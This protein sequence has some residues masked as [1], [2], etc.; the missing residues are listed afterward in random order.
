MTDNDFGFKHLIANHEL[1]IFTGKQSN[2]VHFFELKRVEIR[3]SE[4]H[5]H[6]AL[7]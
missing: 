4:K 6:D 7:L 2:Q 3:T 1:N 5:H